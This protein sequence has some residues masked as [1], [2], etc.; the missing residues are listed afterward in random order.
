M[1]K[2]VIL[3]LGLVPAVASGVVCK[4]ID[5]HG[6]V[7]YTQVPG[8]S[9]PEGLALPQYPN[10]L[11]QPRVHAVDSGV[12]VR[13]VAP[14]DY[15]SFNLSR[16][17]PNGTVRSNDGS[18]TVAVQT[19]PALWSGHF[20]TVLI[21]DADFDG[22][23]GE[24]SVPVSGIE[25]GTHSIQAMINDSAGR[26][27]ARTETTEFTLHGAPGRIQV[28]GYDQ[29]DQVLSGRV[30]GPVL[31]S[32]DPSALTGAS[33]AFDVELTILASGKATTYQ[34]E[35][36]KTD[37]SWSL[38]IPEAELRNADQVLLSLDQSGKPENEGMIRFDKTGDIRRILGAVT[39]SHD[40]RNVP[41]ADYSPPGQGIS[42]TPGKTNPAFAPKY[43]R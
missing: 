6:V 19:E 25:R 9:C 16:P 13:E 1:N 41:G 26:Q 7:T 22:R 37:G 18:F 31:S 38:E 42:T 12:S 17:A 4:S 33:E 28:R 27:I 29:R 35:V 24:S 14:P 32:E 2:V 23:Y 15:Q 30:T 39:G 43:S 36:A 11:R 40:Y 21:D 10:G 3:L 20:I 5:K 34:T 8:T